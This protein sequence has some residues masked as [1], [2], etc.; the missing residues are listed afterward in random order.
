MSTRWVSDSP[1]KFFRLVT[2]NR[3]HGAEPVLA[4]SEEE[5]GFA[6]RLFFL[7]YTE[8][9]VKRQMKGIGVAVSPYR[10]DP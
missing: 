3:A 2:K 1:F 8:P 6:P 7:L 10:L 9:M 5:P 4:T